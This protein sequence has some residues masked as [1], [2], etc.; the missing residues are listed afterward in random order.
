M[1]KS[2]GIIGSGAAGLVTAHI[3]LRDG[4]DVTV[5]TR[6]RSPGG[7]FS[8]D[9]LYP[10]LL[11]NNVHGE[12]RFSALPMPE[13]PDFKETGG[14]L[15]GEDMRLYME[16]YADRFLHNKIRYNVEVTDIRRVNADASPT[17]ASTWTMNIID[18]ISGKQEVLKFDKIVLCTGGSSQA[19][20]PKEFAPVTAFDGMIIHSSEFRAR[21]ED[22]L[23]ATTSKSDAEP[24]DV[25]V[26]GG[27]KSA[28]DI[29]SYLTNSG[30]RVSIVFER[31]DMFMASST[32]LPDFIRRSRFL[33]IVSPHIDLRSRLERF[34]HTSWLGNKI[35]H[36]FWNMVAKSSF[37]ALGI[38]E[39]SPLRLT[40]QFFWGI[41]VNDEGVGRPNGFH[42]LV[43]RGKINLVAPARAVSFGT[44]RKS[45][46]LKDGRILKADAVVLATGFRS[47]W[48]NIFDQTTRDDL[49]LGNRVPIETAKSKNYEWNYTTLANP[50]LAPPE[51][52][53][54]GSSLYRGLVPAKNILQRDFAVNG[55]LFN[56]NRGYVYETSAH[57][58][59]SYFLGDKFLRVPS[60]PEEAFLATE[61]EAAY[62]RKR[63]PDTSLW[64]NESEAVIKFF[65]WP[66]Y[67][68]E[69]LEDMDLPA[70]RSGGNW[71]TWPFKVIDLREISTLSTER[72]A[73]R[74]AA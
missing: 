38:P 47:S 51:N 11:I 10:G 4:F 36:G 19:S 12:Y 18:K 29:A 24:G 14:R 69:L 9:R 66:Q 27:G 20:I 65:C 39:T 42:D 6:D 56:T 26:I 16:S 41:R 53:H 8:A 17:G 72:E 57:W 64:T 63:Y 49:G 45:V 59:S 37:S 73:K 71:L 5:L 54:W 15:S 33:S 28:M 2:I 40:Q 62:L 23:A 70:Y 50:P 25:V 55:A 67:V 68:D 21:L 48:N 58:I 7:V 43:N 1:A 74:A 60:S 31:T 61:R 32:P 13:R 46:V 3:L 34:L 52:Q 44:D 22:F 30:R 35:V